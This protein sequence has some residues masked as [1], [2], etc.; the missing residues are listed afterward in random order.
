M[1]IF[2][3]CLLGGAAVLLVY[4]LYDNNQRAFVSEI[5][6]VVAGEFEYYQRTLVNKT[7]AE[8]LNL[9]KSGAAARPSVLLALINIKG[10]VQWSNASRLPA[11]TDL[12]VLRPNLFLFS[13]SEVV[14]DLDQSSESEEALIVISVVMLPEGRQLWV[15]KDVSSLRQSYQTV[16]WLGGFILLCLLLVVMWSFFISFFVVRRINNIANTA[17]RIMETGDLSQRIS[18]QSTWDDLGNL[19]GLLNVFLARI[20]QLMGAVR[21]VSD[22]IAHDL[23]TPLT[24]L[25]NRLEDSKKRVTLNVTENP[26]S[27]QAV[28][29][30]PVAQDLEHLLSEAD[31]LL[32]VFNAILR[33]S[34][35][36]QGWQAQPFVPVALDELLQDVV[37]LYQ[38][39]AED[40]GVVLQVSGMTPVTRSADPNLLFQAFANTLDN[41][42]KFTPVGGCIQVTMTAPVSLP[43][44]S[45]LGDERSNQL[46]DAMGE[47]EQ[48]DYA[49]CITFADS[50]CGIP[51][52]ERDKVFDRFYRADHSRHSPG[53]GLGLSLVRAAV[54]LH[55]GRILLEDN[56]PGLKCL[57]FL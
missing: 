50:G 12:T 18:I 33:L 23:R 10:Q 48:L 8:Q 2:F 36:E 15:G 19:A 32:A 37:E 49:C 38:P 22:N 28:T 43:E 41:A 34:N 29:L 5:G 54:Q 11:A 31:H 44:Q 42:V 20:E 45:D 30:T 55:G 52:A 1:A 40:K 13:T 56:E 39:L 17:R 25:R 57:I 9:I 6:A 24:R 21:A 47:S 4:T 51:P 46:V 16:N 3:A 53:S 14:W 27:E 26:Q 7:E 35:V